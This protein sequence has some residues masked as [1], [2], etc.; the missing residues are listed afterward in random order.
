MLK[1]E[2]LD[3]FTDAP[4]AGNPLA[5]VYDPDMTLTTEQMQTI[6][7]EFNLSET[8]FVLPPQSP[9]ETATVRIFHPAAEM[10][11]AGHP[12]LGC[13]VALAAREPGEGTKTIRLRTKAGLA[14]CVVIRVS[15]S[16]ASARVTVPVLPNEAGPAPETQT[17]ADALGLRP[18]QIGFAELRPAH[19]VG[20]PDFV[21]V[22]VA[23]RATLAAAR[24]T[25]P[26]F[27][28]LK[29]ERIWGSVYLF[30]PDGDGLQFR[31]RMFAGE[32]FEDPATGSASAILAGVLNAA[33]LLVEGSNVIHLRQG[34]E[35]G[36]PSHVTVHAEVSKASLSQVGIA[37]QA[38]P[39]MRGELSPPP[40]GQP[41]RSDA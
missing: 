36:R 17:L 25:Q 34:F 38:V 14:E 24:I 18:G 1:F 20:G 28:A 23:D 9:D 21:F 35:M 11:F 13:A 7:R 27:D 3:V 5:V 2:T 19:W 26:T 16:A 32:G 40:V 41:I 37:G 6:A 39:V 29:S 30:T 10:P 4:F 15:G 8:I 33:G 12:T 22:P 31:S